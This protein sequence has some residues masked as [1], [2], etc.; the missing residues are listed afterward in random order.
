MTPDLWLPSQPQNTA[1]T[2]D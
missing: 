1:T 2:S